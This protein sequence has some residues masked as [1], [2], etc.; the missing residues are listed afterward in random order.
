QSM[1]RPHSSFREG[2]EPDRRGFLQT[3]TAALL[4]G[5]LTGTVSGTDEAHEPASGADTAVKALYESLTD[6]Q[7]KAMC[8]DWDKKGHGG[9]PL[10][11]H[12]TNN[13]AV[14]NTTVGSLTRDQQ[15]LVGEILK[16]VLN[17]GWPEK[18]AR[19]AQDDT[20]KP[21]TEDRKIA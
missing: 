16:S 19:Q 12:V 15:A 14:S 1:N 5:A 11:L 10:R 7:K 3:S 8:F 6:R 9:L 13:W 21:W 2:A 20:G 18:L 4:G 17:P